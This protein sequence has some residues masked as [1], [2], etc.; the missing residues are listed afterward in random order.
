MLAIRWAVSG[1]RYKNLPAA[2]TALAAVSMLCPVKSS[3]KLCSEGA[4]KWPRVRLP[5]V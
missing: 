2:S 5:T 3:N 4:T 1:S